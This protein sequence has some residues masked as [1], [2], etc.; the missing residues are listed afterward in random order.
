MSAWQQ[1]P[2]ID[3]LMNQ[4][5]EDTH[6]QFGNVRAVKEVSS[7]ANQLG[8]R[9]TLCEAYGAGGWDLRFED[10]KRIGDWLYV[11]GINT[12]NQHLSYVSIRGARKRDHPQSFSYHEPWWSS[13]HASAAYF[14]R[15]SVALSA[16]RQVNPVLVLEPTTTAWMYNT[17]GKALPE[18]EKL[19]SSFQSLVMDLENMQVEYDL[20]CEDIMAR[21]GSVQGASLRVGQAWYTTVVLPPMTGNLNSRTLRLLEEYLKAGG[22]L[23]SLGPPPARVDGSES[24]RPAALARHRG[25]RQV[26]AVGPEL[27]APRDLSIHRAP[28][29][30]GI[31]FHH[32]RTLGD[33]QV[34]FLVN[35]SLEHGSG[36]GVET[37]GGGVERWLPETGGSEPYP[38]EKTGDGVRFSFHL[39]QAG[40]LLVFIPNESRAPAA[41]RKADQAV[42]LQPS[43]PLTVRRIAPNV[44]VIDYMD[45]SAGG[46]SRT[47]TYFYQGSQFAF[48]QNGIPRNPWDS[49]VQFRDEL[50]SV[51]FPPASGVRAAYRFNIVGRVPPSLFA[52]VERA[53]LYNVACNG[54]PVKPLE[55][56]WWLDRSFQKIDIVAAARVG[57]NELSL[58]AAPFSI[59][60]ELE[61]V[62]LLGD[63]VLEPADRGFAMIAD[64]PLN[65]G[66]WNS[67]GHPFYSEGVEYTGKFDVGKPSGA[68]RVTLGRWYGS[69]ARIAVNGKAAGVIHSA[70]WSLDV[71]D[72][73]SDGMNTIEVTVV[74][75]L[76]NTLGPHHDDPQLGTAWP[77]MF[78]KAVSPGPPP[79]KN[80][81]TVSYG[82]H[83][84]FSLVHE[85]RR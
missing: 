41:P 13:Y 8:R 38:F 46:D 16:G 23:L 70:P 60:H 81:A 6:A 3:T 77:A 59:Y 61:P 65:L 31:L 33:G 48:R 63:F 34:L 30:K 75:T 79:G 58:K 69:V 68:Y 29:D 78:Q 26:E 39:P 83:E 12:L 85:Y 7:V 42:A 18:L 35:T 9:R 73:I 57:S 62:Y 15:L 56:S 32:R 24:D 5:R 14:A 53:D 37:G 11:L 19:G 2:G 4:Y 66:P 71:T 84:P 36:G 82:L 47:D 64:R 1:R 10:M 50:I 67:Q 80:Y 76:K 25:W 27:A 43:G 55:N 17:A 28:G 52:V 51:K 72:F 20:G 40:S 49:S 44:L 22:T 54:L 74:G 45:V 21:H